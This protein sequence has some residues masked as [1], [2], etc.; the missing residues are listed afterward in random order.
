LPE[1]ISLKPADV[2]REALTLAY[3]FNFMIAN[4]DFDINV[5]QNLKVVT[6]GSGLPVPVPYDFDWS[7]MVDASYTKTTLSKGSTY[8]DRQK[9][10]ALC[11][12][13]PEYEAALDR[14]RA[15]RE[16]IVQIYEASPYL[17]AESKAEALKNYKGFFARINKAKY[18]RE[19]FISDCE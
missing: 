14:L 11:R 5:R 4:R 10:K 17:S 7:G 1:D 8:E 13:L 16:Q 2:D 19:T 18:I 6:N 3:V 15:V 12:E 9:L